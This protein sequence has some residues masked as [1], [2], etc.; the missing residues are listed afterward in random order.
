MMHNALSSMEEVSYF[1]NHPSNFKVTRDKKPEL[2]VSG[3]WFE[4][5]LTNGYEMGQK[6][7]VA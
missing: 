2:S 1:F 7:G 6:L 3:L 5:E 4:F